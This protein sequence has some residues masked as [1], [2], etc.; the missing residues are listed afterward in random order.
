MREK[1]RERERTTHTH[2]DMEFL[3]KN[4]KKSKMG[5]MLNT[6]QNGNNNKILSF[7]RSLPLK[8]WKVWQWI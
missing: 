1:E 8:L 2:G 6:F 3:L 4:L 7:S 5:T